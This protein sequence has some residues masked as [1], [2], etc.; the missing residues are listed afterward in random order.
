MGGTFDITI[1]N[2]S[3][4]LKKIEILSTIGIRNMGG[5]DFD[6][7]IIS[8]AI[9]DFN[10]KYD[11]DLE[12]DDVAIQDLRLKAEKAKKAL[13]TRQ[14]TTISIMSNGNVLKMEIT[15][16]EFEE[17][18]KS[19]LDSMKAY[20]EMALEDANL[21]WNNISKILLVGGSTRIP[22]VQE[23]IYTVSGIRPSHDL[24]PDE[25]VALGAAYYVDGISENNGF[26]KVNEVKIQDVNSHSL[27]VITFDNNRR[28][29]TTIIKRNSPIP[30]LNERE[31][32]IK[33]EGQSIID[34]EVVE[35]EDEDPDYD[36]IIGKTQLIFDPKPV[37]YP[38][39]IV[40]AYDINGQIHISVKDGMTGQNIGEFNIERAANLTEAEIDDKKNVIDSID[41]E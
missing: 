29:M 21:A 34:L 7:A 3:D 2:L 41:V 11:A 15:R 39:R 17:M 5:F 14:K 31:F 8:K 32:Y 6:N 25:A 12:D 1:M 22:A 38:V 18:I 36:R 30:V 37:G 4:N 13:S 10:A 19:N 16:V 24:N 28:S 26:S 9:N 23:M 40:M 35:G 20:M 33:T 27:G